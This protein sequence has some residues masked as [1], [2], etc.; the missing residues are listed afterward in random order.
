MLTGHAPATATATN[1]QAADGRGTVNVGDGA[2]YALTPRG[3]E[4]LGEWGVTAPAS[5][6]VRCCVDWTEQRHHVGGP[7]GRGLLERFTTLGWFERTRQSRALRLTDAGA[8]GLRE[9]LDADVPDLRSSVPG[10]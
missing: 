10:S 7:L 3:H 1:G 6:V 8:R 5:P 2:G 4:L 9:T